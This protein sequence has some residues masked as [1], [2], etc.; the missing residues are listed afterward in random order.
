MEIATAHAG[1]L[2]GVTDIHLSV[3]EQAGPARAL[4][5]SLGFSV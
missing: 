3:S 1:T 4:Y 5:G 2:D